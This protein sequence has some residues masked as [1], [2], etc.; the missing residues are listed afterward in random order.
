MKNVK[1]FLLVLFL[2]S[3]LQPSFSQSP[4]QRD[5]I[6]KPYKASLSG[7][8]GYGLLFFA[9]GVNAQFKIHQNNS[10]N[11]SG[12]WLNAGLGVSGGI[13]HSARSASLKIDLLKGKDDSYFEFSGGILIGS[14]S[15]QAQD[16]QGLRYYPDVNIGY[17]YQKER[18]PYFMRIGIGYPEYAYFSFGFSF[19]Q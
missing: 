18:N 19:L 10:F 7:Y 12:V 2:F 14:Y 6:Y 17:R 8:G 1:Y 13:N 3:W 16:S 9:A 5:S 4:I 11:H 15:T